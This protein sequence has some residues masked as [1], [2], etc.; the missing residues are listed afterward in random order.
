[1]DDGEPSEADNVHAF[2][3]A[4]ARRIV[5]SI[6]TRLAKQEGAV[7]ELEQLDVLVKREVDDRS[8]EP[9]RIPDTELMAAV[10]AEVDVLLERSAYMTVG[11]SGLFLS[12]PSF[13]EKFALFRSVEDRM[14]RHL[15]A[16]VAARRD[17]L[18]AETRAAVAS[19]EGGDPIEPLEATRDDLEVGEAG[20]SSEEGDSSERGG[21][22]QAV[23]LRAS[24]E[25]R[26][27]EEMESSGPQ[28]E[29]RRE[30][31]ILREAESGGATKGIGAAEIAHDDFDL[32]SADTVRVASSEVNGLSS[33]GRQVIWNPKKKGAAVTSGKKESLRRLDDMLDRVRYRRAG[34]RLD[35]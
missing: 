31:E 34:G 15:D 35:D 29:D 28:G 32:E 17:E 12:T 4:S 16:V 10:R 27:T 8:E 22:E 6:T 7:F 9:A 3:L 30:A 1:M 21:A 11:T 2:A 24:A 14:L 26:N 13:F 25:G 20:S 23:A 33:E 5:S 19:T 18:E